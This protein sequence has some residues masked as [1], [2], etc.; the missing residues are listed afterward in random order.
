MKE[1]NLDRLKEGISS[2]LSKEDDVSAVYIFGSMVNDYPRRASSDIDIGVLFNKRVGLKRE[3]DLAAR[4]TVKL[5]S[6]VDLVN[7]D[8]IPV[9]LAFQVVL[10]GILVFEKVRMVLSD[11]LERLFGEYQDFRPKFEVFLKEYNR[12]LE[13]EFLS[14]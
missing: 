10:K 9:N 11:Y 3:L 7:L 8:R 14:G 6:E 5:G 4:L 13:E 2:M 1:R 12:S